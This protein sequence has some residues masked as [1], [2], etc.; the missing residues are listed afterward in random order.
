MSKFAYNL[1]GTS[2]LYATETLLLACMTD[3]WG[4]TPYY[5]EYLVCGGEFPPQELEHVADKVSSQDI[6][7]PFQMPSAISQSHPEGGV[8]GAMFPPERSLLTF[9]TFSCS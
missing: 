1:C 2:S 8:D 4:T 6:V 5:S 3:F 9:F 7:I